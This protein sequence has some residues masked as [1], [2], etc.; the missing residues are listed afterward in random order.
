MHINS[1]ISII[2]CLISL[3]LFSQTGGDNIYDFLNLT[4]SARVASLGGNNV[5][6]KDNDLDLTFH[7]PSLLNSSMDNQLALNYVNYFAD[8]NY[9][10]I[11]YARDSKEHGTFAIGLHHIN[12]GEFTETNNIGEITGQFNAAEYALNLIWSKPINSL[13]SFGIN[14]KPIYSELEK[15]KSYGI[16][17]DAGVT[18]FNPDLQL[19]A[20]L[21]LKNFGRQLTTYYENNSEPLPFEVQLGISKKLLHA[22]FRFSMLVHHLETY[23]L[24]F[25]E[26]NDPEPTNSSEYSDTLI[27]KHGD[28]FFDNILRHMIFGVELLPTKNF[29]VRFGYNFK[30]RR[31]LL[32]TSKPGGAG[33]SWGVGFRISKFHFNYGRATYHLAGPS[34]HFSINTNLSDFYKKTK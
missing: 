30:R 25:E 28:K 18:Y 19:S 2:L 21:V 8:I 27:V 9:G 6:I 3:E 15:Y 13:F 14:I 34:N 20:A 4:N 10:Y 11:S 32:I 1:I 7:N 26:I 17:A 16:A 23:D 5:S 29:S 31:E 22:P 24:S 33:L 12:Y